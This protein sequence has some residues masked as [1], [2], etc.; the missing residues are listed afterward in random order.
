MQHG[1]YCL[2]CL[3]LESITP[4]VNS[5]IL[6]LCHTG[7]QLIVGDKSASYDKCAKKEWKIEYMR[8]PAEQNINS[9]DW[10]LQTKLIGIKS[11]QSWRC[12]RRFS[13]VWDPIDRL[14]LRG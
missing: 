11:Y 10:S 13:C 4:V 3:P 9:L 7:F 1:G 6:R 8:S 14:I 2:S 12:L 5:L